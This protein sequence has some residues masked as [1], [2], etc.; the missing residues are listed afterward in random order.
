MNS[1]KVIFANNEVINVQPS[2]QRFDHDSEY[3]FEHNG[4]IMYAMVN[5][6][7][8]DDA[9]DGAKSLI[10]NINNTNRHINSLPFSAAA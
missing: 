9:K 5:A 7:N 3:Y 4:Q 8:E 1:Y 10:Y 6:N 2:N